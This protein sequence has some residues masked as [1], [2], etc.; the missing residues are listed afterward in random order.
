[1][2]IPFTNPSVG[3]IGTTGVESTLAGPAIIVTGGVIGWQYGK[4]HAEE[5]E[6]WV[7]TIS[8]K[9]GEWLGT[10]KKTHHCSNICA[11]TK[12]THKSI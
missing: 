9:I 1:M 7:M 10:D 8:Y 3:N 4:D 11:T 5:I 12:H 2:V 6:G